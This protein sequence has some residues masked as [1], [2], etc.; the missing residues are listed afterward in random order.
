MSGLLE[1]VIVNHNT[2]V[3]AEIALRSLR[4]S[5]DRSDL[6]DRVRITMVDNHSTDDTAA[7]HTAIAECGA[8]WELSRWPIG[9]QSLTTHGDVLRD[10]VLARPDAAAFAFVE[11]D[12]CFFE[13]DTMAVMSGELLE[14][15]DVWAVQARMLSP[16]I[17]P[18]ESLFATT[19]RRRRRAL[20]LT[21]QIAIPT[22][23]GGSSTMELT[24]QARKLPRCHPGCTLVRNSPAFEL[25][26]R[27]L[28]FS[29]SWSWSNDTATGGLHD[30]L[31]LVSNVMRTH[32]RR[33]RVSGASVIH[34]WHG[35]R[36]GVTA[37]HRRLLALLRANAFDEFKSA[38]LTGLNPPV[39]GAGTADMSQ[40]APERTVS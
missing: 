40:A 38:A 24:H 21:A 10:F 29:A 22:D 35:S 23:D 12:M 30:T 37:H 25:A 32:H 4:W 17:P 11:S 26:A 15:A 2:S 33:S 5:I 31:G 3:F 13:P 18:D 9:Q 14:A 20:S 8:S 27:H 7:L 6:G 16:G 36:L 19:V 1:A 34:F 28:G 39:S